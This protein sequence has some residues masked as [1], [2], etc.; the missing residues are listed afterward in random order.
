MLIYLHPII[1]ENKKS[2][3]QKS[4]KKLEKLTLDYNQRVP[5]KKT[6]ILWDLERCWNI[7]LNIFLKT[8]TCTKA[9]KNIDARAFALGKPNMESCINKA[10]SAASFVTFL[11]F[12]VLISGVVSPGG[13]HVTLVHITWLFNKELWLERSCKVQA[14]PENS[15]ESTKW[16]S[17]DTVDL[18][19]L[20][21][22]VAD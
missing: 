12:C 15:H 20:K 22:K 3:N 4:L 19:H 17:T 14:S 21:V 13:N 1:K 2:W 9:E 18:R 5:L 6:S 7:N 11:C 10:T 8:N 16:T